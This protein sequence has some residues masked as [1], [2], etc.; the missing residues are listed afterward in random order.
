MSPIFKSILF[1]VGVFVIFSAI[2]LVL[3]LATGKELDA[4]YLGLFSKTD[5]MLGLA[6]AVIVTLN[7]ERKKKSK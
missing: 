2:A 1:G 5:L 4:E 7:H 6:V 3:K